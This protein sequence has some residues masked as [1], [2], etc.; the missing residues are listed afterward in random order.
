M[1]TATARAQYALACGAFI[2]GVSDH[3]PDGAEFGLTP[4]EAQA[5][6]D[7]VMEATEFASTFD[8]GEA[9]ARRAA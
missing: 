6:L 2:D 3:V 7:L 5:T 1:T 8:C 9:P 4:E